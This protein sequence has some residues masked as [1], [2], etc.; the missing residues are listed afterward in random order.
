MLIAERNRGFKR[1]EVFQRLEL[2][3]RNDSV[4][5]LSLLELSE[6]QGKRKEMILLLS[7]TVGLI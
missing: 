4:A 2:E 5:I 7:S 1:G 6:D 3:K